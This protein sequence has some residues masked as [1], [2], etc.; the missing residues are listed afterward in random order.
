MSGLTAEMRVAMTA[1]NANIGHTRTK[2]SCARYFRHDGKKV[3]EVE[4]TNAI[5]GHSMFPYKSTAMAVDPSEVPEVQERLRK[6][7][8]FVEFDR[9][10]RP[11]ITSTKQH[12]AL[13][14]AM[15]MKTGRD[16]FG[17]T[18]EYGNFQNS[19]RRR[20]DEVQ[21][22]R[23]RVQKAIQKLESMPEEVPAHVVAGVLKEYDICPIEENTG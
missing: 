19:G 23:N 22:G 1:I 5:V 21:A 20:N 6:E 18:D 13:A 17:H 4:R 10:G 15:G 11:E 3:I 8:L 7:G 2:K 9:E 14:K 12:D 16:G